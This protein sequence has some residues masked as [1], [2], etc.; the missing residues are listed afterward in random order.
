MVF[1][2][3]IGWVSRFAV[4][5]QRVSNAAVLKRGLSQEPGSF[6]R[7]LVQPSLFTEEPPFTRWPARP[8]PLLCVANLA[9]G[10]YSGIRST[11]VI[12]IHGFTETCQLQAS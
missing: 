12:L 3:Q 4:S 8:L 9:A 1:M 6:N 10:D 2:A 11:A 5:C 7:N